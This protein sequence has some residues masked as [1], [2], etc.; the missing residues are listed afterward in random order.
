MHMQKLGQPW[1]KTDDFLMEKKTVSIKSIHDLKDI[2]SDKRLYLRFASR[3]VCI[4]FGK[5]TWS[6]MRCWFY[7]YKEFTRHLN[8]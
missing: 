5:K 8:V 6:R 4:Y 2:F 3:D 1:L 7:L